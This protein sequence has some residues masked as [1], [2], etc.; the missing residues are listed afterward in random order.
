MTMNV[1]TTDDLADYDGEDRAALHQLAV[2]GRRAAGWLRGL[3]DGDQH[4]ADM[5]DAVVQATA[6]FRPYDLPNAAGWENSLSDA[7]GVDAT[8]RERL[9]G[10]LV[11]PAGLEPIELVVLDAVGGLMLR[12]V[13]APGCSSDWCLDATAVAAALDAALDLVADNAG[14][15]SSS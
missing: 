12:A 3:V 14:K 15:S 9:L 4:L 2:A 11:D 8:V 1:M 5:A 6:G 7:H 10:R 13:S